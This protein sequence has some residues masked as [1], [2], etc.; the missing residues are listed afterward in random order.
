MTID[1]F[2][3]LYFLIGA[4]MALA[5]NPLISKIINDLDESIRFKY[6]VFFTAM[7]SLILFWAPVMAWDAVKSYRS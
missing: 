6:F 3:T 2:M 1:N 5:F 4:S 7:V